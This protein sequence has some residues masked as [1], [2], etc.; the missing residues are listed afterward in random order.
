M[1]FRKKSNDPQVVQDLIAL[2]TLL[3]HGGKGWIKGAMD[4]LK[5]KRMCHCLVGGTY[6]I[7][8]GSPYPNGIIRRDKLIVALATAV[9]EVSVRIRAVNSEG[10]CIEYNDRSRTRWA[11]IENV[12]SIAVKT[13]REAAHG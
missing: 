11:D 5:G 7:T 9:R 8:A 10:V 3:N 2:H 1:R 12:I 13:E 4:K 6:K